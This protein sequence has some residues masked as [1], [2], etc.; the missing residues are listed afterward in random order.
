MKKRL[1]SL[2]VGAFV[3]L[4]ANSQTTIKET[5]GFKNQ[6]SKIK[7]NPVE[8]ALSASLTCNTSYVAGS[9][10][11]LS[12]TL[13]PNADLE[14]GA[15]LELT[16]PTGITPNSGTDP[17]MA[18]DLGQPTADLSISG[19]TCTWT[20]GDLTF[21]GIVADGSAIDFIVNVTIDGGISGDQAVNYTITG[22]GYNVP[23]PT[24]ITGTV[25]VLDNNT[26]F[27]DAKVIE[28]VILANYDDGTNSFYRVANCGL[29]DVPVAARIV[30]SGNTDIDNFSI[31]YQLGNETPI[32]ETV[33]DI[34]AGG[35]SLW[36][37]FT[38]PIASITEDLHE[39]R[40]YASVASDVNLANDTSGYIYFANS[41]LTDL[42]NENY[43]NTFDT[44]LEKFSVYK[45]W[46]GQGGAFGNSSLYTNNGSAGALFFSPNVTL[47]WPEGVYSTYVFTTCVEVTAG[48]SYVIKY[49]RKS[50]E[51]SDAPVNGE[52]A[53]L[54]GEEYDVTTLDTI[55]DFTAITPNAPD[56]A[57]EKDS[58]I[59]VASTDGVRYFSIAGR[60]ETAGTS[61]APTKLGNVRVD[62][63]EVYLLSGVG[64]DENSLNDFVIYPNP[65]SDIVNVSLKNPNGM[66][67]LLSTDGKVIESRKVSSNTETFNVG[68]LKA[69]VYF[70]QVGQSVKKLMIK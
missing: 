13:S 9:T 4:T 67:S 8:K 11:D 51:S 18:V 5:R 60:A 21:G 44:D 1:L 29:S 50:N 20:S 69:G 54:T 36:Y 27:V 2:V 39:I 46:I 61:Q 63:I 34:I 53:I 6:E 38:T 16:F 41:L 26:P 58:V 32:T 30:N 7:S 23:S 37:Y 48:S 64:I 65:S 62:D 43:T 35:D 56:G 70:I 19:Q 24:V 3:G 12:F 42:D 52:T 57:W 10:M 22:D 25:N 14:Y 31:S 17:F 15:I 59:Y 68:S 40:S 66:I 28:T 49:Y 55:R 45:T 33:S 47:G